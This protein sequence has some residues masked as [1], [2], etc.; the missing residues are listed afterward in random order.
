MYKHKEDVKKLAHPILD[1]NAKRSF[2]LKP[3][4]GGFLGDVIIRSLIRWNGNKLM[5]K[6]VVVVVYQRRKSKVQKKKISV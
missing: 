4:G 2:I 5:I 1:P 6:K 3:G